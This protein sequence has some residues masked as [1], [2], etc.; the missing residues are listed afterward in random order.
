MVT[1]QDVLTEYDVEAMDETDNIELPEEKL[2]SG[3]KG[4]LIKLA[5]QLRDRRNELNQMASERASKRDDLNAKTREKVDEA[6]EHREERDRLNE[7]VQEHKNSRNELNAEANELFDKV[8]QLK[9]DLDL[10]DG[11]GVEELKEEIEDL[12]FRQQTEVLSAED[13]RELI[14]KNREQARAPRRP[15]GEN[16]TRPATWRSSSRRQR[17]SAPRRPGTTRR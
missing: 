7:K 5:G 16:S 10:D 6:Q 11:K 4:E 12:E 1:Q 9:T 3:S 14:E 2:E 13:E 17:R 15:Q 8:E